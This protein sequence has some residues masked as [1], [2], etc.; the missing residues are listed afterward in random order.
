MTG[1]DDVQRVFIAVQVPTAAKQ[2]L[3]KLIDGL[4]LEY[5]R[6]VRWVAPE[7]IHLT[8]KFL[9]NVEASRISS[10]IES[11]GAA[12]KGTGPFRL[13]VSGLGTFPNA[14]RPRVLWAGVTGDLEP[15]LELQQRVE[16]AMAGLGFAKDRQCFN[17]HLTLGRVRDRVSPAN[18]QGIGA[19]FSGQGLASPEPWLV[20]EVF[21][22]QSRLGPQRATYSDL[23]AR[24]FRAEK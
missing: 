7:G 18:R 11:M 23:A 16:N 15:L 8:L 2:E 13:Q 6:D 12:A 22:V 10:V 21:L 9:G 5:S 1:T 19:A 14:A 3:G 17:P 4:A 20:E 24:P